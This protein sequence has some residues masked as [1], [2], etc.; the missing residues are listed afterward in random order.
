M[1][2]FTLQSLLA[3]VTF[4]AVALASLL[5]PWRSWCPAL[6]F[7][8]STVLLLLAIPAAVCS[9]NQA[10]ARY[11]GFAVVG[12]GYFLLAYTT[13]F[14]S[15]LA[16]QLLA[17]P[18]AQL[19]CMQVTGSLGDFPHFLNVTHALFM[20]LFASLGALTAG[21]VYAHDGTLKRNGRASRTVERRRVAAQ[22]N[23]VLN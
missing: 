8:G 19:L 10:R 20:M 12:W 15:R 6:V 22:G 2:R 14:D 3:A 13:W 7:T 16:T 21:R 9:R 23:K 4:V 18:V 1:F 5:G 17:W 11:L